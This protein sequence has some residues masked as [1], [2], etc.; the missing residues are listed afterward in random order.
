MKD[1]YL[2][3][4]L[5]EVGYGLLDHLGIHVLLVLQL[6]AHLQDKTINFEN[7]SGKI[8]NN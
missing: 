2:E 4:G 7:I 1:D 5:L 6:G 8:L 3:T